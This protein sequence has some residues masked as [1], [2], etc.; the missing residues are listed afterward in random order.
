MSLFDF[1]EE[2]EKAEYA[3][4][5]P[6]VG[7]YPKEQILMFE[8]EVM[9]IYV[10]GHPLENDEN[11]WKGTIT[12]LTSDFALDEENGS[13]R[14]SDQSRQVIG[15]MVE[16]KTVKYTKQN[17]AMCFFQLEDLVGSVEVVVFP[18]DYERYGRYIEEDA[19]LFVRGRVSAED[20]KA[21]K[22]I[23]ESITPFSDIPQDIWIQFPTLQ[24]YE[25]GKEKLFSLI[26]GGDGKN[27]VVLYIRDP[28][29]IRRLGPAYSVNASLSLMEQLREAFGRDNVKCAVRK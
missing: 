20:D 12:A 23:C 29:A 24:K 8:K 18:K 14:V 17:K 15:G 21:S 11:V 3:I 2:E 4:S 16:N 5:L 27:Q 13:T 25:E 22:L 9:G 10:S 6:N 7:E 1:M 19:K 26:A 28:K